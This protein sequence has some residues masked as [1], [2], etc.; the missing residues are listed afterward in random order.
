MSIGM[1]NLTEAPPARRKSALPPVGSN[2]DRN[3]SFAL[4]IARVWNN[5]RNHLVA[6][7]GERPVWTVNDVLRGALADDNA[8]IVGL[9]A[10]PCLQERKPVV[11]LTYRRAAPLNSGSQRFNCQTAKRDTCRGN[12][13]H[14]EFDARCGRI[15]GNLDDKLVV[16]AWICTGR[17]ANEGKNISAAPDLRN[18]RQLSLS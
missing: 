2:I 18:K 3:Y 11:E 12:D 13:L 5:R 7:G 8:V 4:R 1:L 16:A 10:R 9:R 15:R 17:H 6:T 14:K